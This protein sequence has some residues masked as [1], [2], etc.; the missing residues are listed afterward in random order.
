MEPDMIAD[1]ESAL[2]VLDASQYQRW[3][4][5]GAAL[6]PLGDE[7]F[8]LWNNWSRTGEGY[9]ERDAVQKWRSFKHSRSHPKAVFKYAREQGWRP[10]GTPRT[11]LSP[12]P[13]AKP[14]PLPEL[15]PEPR[16]LAHCNRLW[17]ESLPL[18]HPDA[19]P[20][21]RYFKH[22]DIGAILEDLPGNI[23]FHPR[24]SYHN[25]QGVTHH[26][27]II[28]RIQNTAGELVGVH[29]TYLTPDGRKADV[30]EP[31]KTLGRPLPP[32]M[33][34]RLYP[35]LPGHPIAIAEGLETALAV[36]IGCDWIAQ[37]ANVWCVVH[38]DGMT[39]FEPPPGV[40][41][42]DIWADRDKSRA[43]EIAADALRQRLEIP[44]RVLMPP[45][46]GRGKGTDWLDAMAYDGRL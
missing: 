31:K 16:T 23:R 12:R 5:V 32:G 45:D 2:S 22:R 25:G 17:L 28:A 3:I 40:S 6:A 1:L 19:E 13:R 24:L 15:R 18:T 29:R 10:S 11:P 26:P 41:R 27:A 33:A 21:R 46:L 14:P 4:E 38:A 30:P 39:K 9:R 8:Q 43:G 42:L 20:A 44:A 36:R 35:H 34:I 37:T 7:G